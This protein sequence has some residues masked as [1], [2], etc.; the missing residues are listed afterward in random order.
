MIIIII[1]ICRIPVSPQ[2]VNSIQL[3]SSGLTIGLDGALNET[4][5]FAFY[6]NRVYTTVDCNFTTISNNKM[7]IKLDLTSK[8]SS[9]SNFMLN[10][11]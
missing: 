4:V 3:N 11:Q 8:N 7:R 5:T 10:C 6:I 9:S 1:I 2:R